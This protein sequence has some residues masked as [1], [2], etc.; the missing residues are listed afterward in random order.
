[1]LSFV[2]GALAVYLSKSIWLSPTITHADSSVEKT[3]QIPEIKFKN[4]KMTSLF[5][6]FYNDD[7]FDRSLDP[8]EDMRKM[9]E[10]ILRDFDNPE[11]STGAFDSWFQKKFG[12]GSVGD[13]KKR[14]DSSFVYYDISTKG[15]DP[16]KL[17]VKV[18]NNQ[19]S[20]SGETENKSEGD[21]SETYSKSSFH[22]SFPAPGHVDAEKVHIEQLADK[23]V[24]KFPKTKS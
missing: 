18:E 1:M 14:E 5:D 2:A 9:R 8:F 13:I 10:R 17:K 12:G 23:L 11:E 22:R 4:N 19:I 16:K 6:Q 7:F 21:H 20:I 24:L 15:L 3:E